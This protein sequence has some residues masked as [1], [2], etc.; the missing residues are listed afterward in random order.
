MKQGGYVVAWLTGSL[1]LGCGGVEEGATSEAEAS[2]SAPRVSSSG[3][4]AHDNAYQEG[5]AATS[6]LTCQWFYGTSYDSTEEA[7]AEAIRQGTQYCASR[8]GVKS[9]GR[10]CTL[11][12]D[13]PP[14]LAGNS[15][16]CVL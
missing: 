12:A 6:Q 9:R 7:C 4:T 11:S 16:C 15:I 3:D 8:G 5:P 14:Y 13:G 1:L 2:L 10:L